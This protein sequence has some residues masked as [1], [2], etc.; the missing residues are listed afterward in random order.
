MGNPSSSTLPSY[1]VLDA[2]D[3]LE[4]LLQISAETSLSWLPALDAYLVTGYEHVLEALKHPGLQAANATQGFER[5]TAA[6]QEALR[7]LRMSIDMWMGHTNAED[8]HRFQQLLKRYFTPATVNGLRPRVREL[9]GELLDAVVPRGRMEVVADLAYPLPAN[10]IAEMFGM[11]VADRPRLRAW[12]REIGAVF[13]NASTEQLLVSQDSVL[14]MQDYLREILADRR[15]RPTDDLISMFAAAERE[16]VVT[17]DEIVANCVLLLFAGHETTANLI[18]R[19]LHTLMANPDQLA[20][21]RAEPDRTRAAIEEMLRTSGPVV[22]VVRQTIEPVT[23]AGHDLPA[24]KHLFLA[25]YTA[26]HDPEVFEN[27][28]RFDITRK[29]NRHLTFGMGAYYCL[30]AALARVESDECFRLLLARC[31]NLHPAG[32]A[33]L[34]SVAPFGRRV[35]S[36]PVEF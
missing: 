3:P 28:L 11:P 4:H 5:L 14:E 35:E 10:I 22:T 18:A 23:L 16:G 33:T 21:L 24:G 12:S 6:E 34:V 32:D 8:H 30:G 9:T 15:T 31:P 26:N 25:V 20:L 7:P 2:S 29:N 17:E 1:D 27:P 36:V 13:G 19:G